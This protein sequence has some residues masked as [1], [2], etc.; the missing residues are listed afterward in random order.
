MKSQF[1]YQ[2]FQPLDTLK[3]IGP[4]LKS[5]LKYLVGN[6]VIDL[7]WHL[8]NG[9]IDRSYTPNIN[10]AEI[11]RVATIKCIVKKHA[12]SYRRNIPYKV[13]CYDQSGEITLVWFNS[14]KDYL[15]ELLPLEKEILVSG[16][17]DEY[18]NN[19]QITH[20]DHK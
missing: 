19:K 20:P 13:D 4:K 18:K 14:R 3:G 8:P 12:P 6:Y 1:L 9:F 10:N 11:G 7:L 5:R 17:V 15:E 2:L 16:L